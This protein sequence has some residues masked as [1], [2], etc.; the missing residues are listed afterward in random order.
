[1]NQTNH[2]L[3]TTADD[4]VPTDAVGILTALSAAGACAD[5]RDFAGSVAKVNARLQGGE[6]VAECDRAAEMGMPWPAYAVI[7]AVQLA[8]DAGAAVHI[9]DEAGNVILWVE[10]VAGVTEFRRASGALILG[11]A[12]A[13][14][15]NYLALWRPG[16]MN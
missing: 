7:R 13:D 15:D 9:N 4:A 1:M 10:V 11:L 12:I 3:P 5:S 2:T 6:R 14:I 8:R 16:S